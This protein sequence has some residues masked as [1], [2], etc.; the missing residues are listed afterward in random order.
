MIRRVFWLILLLG[1]TASS[2]PQRQVCVNP[3]RQLNPPPQGAF[4]FSPKNAPIV[5]F[6][7]KDISGFTSWLAD[8]KREDPRGVFSVKDG[9]IRI[10]GD[11]FGYLCTNFSFKDYRLLT[12]FKWGE[13]NFRE[14]EGKA[15]DSGVFVHVDGP[16]GNSH[17]G[18]GAY[19][20]GIECQVMEGAVGDLLKIRGSWII[21]WKQ[22]GSNFKAETLV[23]P[24]W[25]ANVS[26]DKDEEG[27][28]WWSKDGEE[29]H[30]Q[31]MAGRVN[32]QRKD[33]Q[34]KDV[35][36]FRGKEDVESKHG[37]WTTVECLCAGDSIEVKVNGEVVNRIKDV[38]LTSGQILL[39]CEGSE[40]Y[41]RRLELHPVTR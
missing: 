24:T 33:R 11:G 8:T 15:R 3:R 9:M 36:G 37:E 1:A 14:R 7:G 30:D 13:K 5:L 26:Q 23:K 25:R 18:N 21:E 39:Q 16:D 17:D 27:Y 32:W 4:A 20:A 40:I 34:W 19:K 28:Y 31:G 35:L 41:F 6:N 2:T 38:N 22:D 29:Y 12:E 10:S